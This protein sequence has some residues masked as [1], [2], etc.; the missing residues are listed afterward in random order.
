MN[1]KLSVN[2]FKQGKRY[3]AYVPS[4]DI[5]TSGK[6][7]SEVKKRFEELIQIFF[8]ELRETD[9]LDEVLLG[10]GWNKIQ[11]K[12]RIGQWQPPKVINKSIDVRIPVSI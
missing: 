12:S 3:V 5:S 11:M 10:L 1:F 4:L 9:N 7:E 8:E 6:T 2:I